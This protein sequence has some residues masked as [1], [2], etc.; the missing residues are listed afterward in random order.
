MRFNSEDI[1]ASLGGH[2]WCKVMKTVIDENMLSISEENW[3]PCKG[4]GDLSLVNFEEIRTI[5]G[6]PNTI[7]NFLNGDELSENLYRAHIGQ[8]LRFGHGSRGFYEDNKVINEAIETVASLHS[9]LHK[10]FN[11]DNLRNK[12]DKVGFLHND[13]DNQVGLGECRLRKLGCFTAIESF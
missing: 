2:Y 4:C 9:I 5:L 10:E 11:K 7:K 1:Y 6:S 8:P 13:S 3:T 12:R